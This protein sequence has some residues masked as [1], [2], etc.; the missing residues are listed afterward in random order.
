MARIPYAARS[1]ASASSQALFD[2]LEAPRGKP[3]E[4]VFLAVANAPSLCEGVLAMAMSLRQSTLLDRQLRELA[5]L[6]V[7][8]ETQAEYEVA[9]HWNSAVKAGIPHDKLDRLGDFETDPA[10]TETERTVMRVAATATRSGRVDDALWDQLC[11]VLGEPQRLEL[12]LTIAW[13]NCV[14][15]ILLPFEIG[16]EDWYHRE[17]TE[18]I[19]LGPPLSR[20]RRPR[21]VDTP[22][23]ARST[24]TQAPGTTAR[25]TSRPVRPCR[26]GTPSRRS[27]PRWLTLPV[28]ALSATSRCR[29]PSE[30]GRIAAT[31]RTTPR[32]RHQ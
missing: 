10:F 26:K 7:G 31:R 14:V 4:N 5:V 27:V 15:C 25:A 21:S 8:L 6:T 19:M 24:S 12:V 1:E 17:L 13:Y 9:H 32:V 11:A 29:R 22:R 2:R 30:P 3:V 23:P 18:P 16:I 20:R 28:A